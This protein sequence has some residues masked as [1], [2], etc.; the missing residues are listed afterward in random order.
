MMGATEHDRHVVGT[1]RCAVPA[2]VQRAERILKNERITAHVAPLNKAPDGAARH[3]YQGC[4]YPGT[5]GPSI[6]LHH[7]YLVFR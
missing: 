7:P 4:A 5:P 3:P 6:A 1:A 2:R